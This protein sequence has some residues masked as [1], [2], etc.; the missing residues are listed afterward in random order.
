MSAPLAALIPREGVVCSDA[1]AT[2]ALGEALG[3]ML[4]N[5]AVLALVGP[6]GAGKT[7][8]T[9]GLVRALGV[10]EEAAS[11]SFAIVHEYPGGRLPVF[12]YDFYRLET[13]DE[14]LTIGFD[15]ALGD[16]VTIVEWADKFPGVFPLETLWLTFELPPDGGRRVFGQT[17]GPP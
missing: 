11:P 13:V 17:G 14:L 4:T 7:C 1:A 2:A 9:A 15:D 8:L 16:G 12:H 5:G 6:L 3:R 10:P